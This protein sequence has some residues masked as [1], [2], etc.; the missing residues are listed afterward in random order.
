MTS[1]EIL[2]SEIELN[3]N[4][5]FIFPTL[6]QI[7]SVQTYNEIPNIIY[8]AREGKYDLAGFKRYV[9]ERE[10]LRDP[11]IVPYMVSQYQRLTNMVAEGKIILEGDLD[12]LFKG[13]SGVSDFCRKR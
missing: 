2:G 11:T 13:G 4:L 10:F 12:N 8:D 7:Q 5:L 9:L 3:Q 6:I 1:F